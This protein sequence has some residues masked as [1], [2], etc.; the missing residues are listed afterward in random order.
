MSRYEFRVVCANGNWDDL[1]VYQERGVASATAADFDDDDDCG[2]HR[3]ERRAC[4]PFGPSAWKRP[5]I[6]VRYSVIMTAS[7]DEEADEFTR[8]MARADRIWPRSGIAVLELS[9]EEVA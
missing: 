1:K 7:T 2:P 5:V 6:E 8:Y 3:I 9:R 4:G